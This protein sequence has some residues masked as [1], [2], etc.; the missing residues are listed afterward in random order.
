[1]SRARATTPS[2]SVTDLPVRER[3]M[4]TACRLFYDEGI[5]A[6][7]IQRLIDEAGIAK[8]S[9]YAHFSSKDD[10][11]AAYL[12]QKGGRRRA[13]VQAHLDNPRLSAR[14]KILKIFDMIAIEVETPGFRGCPF[15]NAT[16]EV[17]DP[18]HPIR[19]AARRQREWVHEVIMRLAQET[20]ARRRASGGVAHRPPRR[21]A[22]DRPHRRR[23]GRR[24][25][26]PLGGR[27]LLG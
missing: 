21:R 27:K 9:L 15:H 13:E 22:G 7:G 8:A 18:E 20:G 23:S 1:M 12:D 4:A 5:Q 3:I 24:A 2:G 17:A 16:A 14:G 25:P 6:V 10:L 19:L 11:V 26:R